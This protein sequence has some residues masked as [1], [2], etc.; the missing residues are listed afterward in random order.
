MPMEEV[1]PFHNAL[2]EF[3]DEQVRVRGHIELLMTFACAQIILVKFLI[4]ER[5]SPYNAIL[6]CKSINWG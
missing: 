2:V 3:A 1:G 5:E 6:Q 4:I